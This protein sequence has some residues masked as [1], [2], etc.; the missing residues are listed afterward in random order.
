MDAPENG[1]DGADVLAQLAETIDDGFVV[2][3]SGNRKADRPKPIRLDID[4]V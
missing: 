3:F 2:L 4:E 1:H